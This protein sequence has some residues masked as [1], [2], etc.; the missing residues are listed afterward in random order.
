MKLVE[1]IPNFSEGRNP[2]TLDA[3]AAAIDGVEGVKLLDV[4][5]GYGANRTV[6]TFIGEPEPMGEAAFQAIRVASELIDMSVQ[7]GEHPRM[8]AT[9][10][11]PFVPVQ[12]VDMEDCVRLAE[13]VGERVASEL[14]IPIYLYEYASRSEERRL[15]ANIRSGE[16]EGLADKITNPA[17]APDFGEPLFNPKAGA[18][19]M[20]ARKFLIAY[21][22]NLN[23]RDKRLADQ[24][25]FRIREKGS[26]K[27]DTAG[28]IVRDA[29]GK[30][31]MEPG[32]FKYVRAIGW[33][34]PEYDMA[35]VSMNLTD[36]KVS[37]LHEV[38]EAACEEAEA[39]GLRVTGCEL[40]G[41]IPLEVL[42]DAGAYFLERQGSSPGLPESELIR[43][44][45]QTLGLAELGP[46]DAEKRIIEYR[47]DDTEGAFRKG[48]VNRFFDEISMGTS[49]P[50][51]GSAAAAMAAAASALVSMVANLTIGKKGYEGVRERM[52]EIA[53]GAQRLRMPLMH[54]ID[55]DARAY[56]R[57]M[58]AFRLPRGSKAEE[59]AREQAIVS[60]T[61]EAIRVPMIVLD[62]AV[63][64]LELAEEATFQ[65]N[66]NSLSD[67][68]VAAAAAR[69]A[70][71]GAYFNVLINL[72]TLD[73]YDEG[74]R[75]EAESLA[76]RANRIADGI[77]AYTREKLGGKPV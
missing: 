32:R 75:S 2:K 47:F 4:D 65:G 58:E 52:K 34:I 61:M 69:A 63:R 54:A 30:A 77:S 13:E 11:C 28:K 66:V 5:P 74:V 67:A 45:V 17:W 41:L 25:A 38:F 1:C 37:P 10:V 7:K 27:R 62:G 71:E 51:G 59:E 8:G 40:V 35:Q 64:T 21:N 76:E 68:A 24:V 3:I 6:M 56:N 60:A 55:D 49:T 72:Q 73:G 36:H 19:V 20:G 43:V 50:G 31:V 44:A 70:A 18:T 42:R 29:D 14:G 46:F 26:A 39:H 53:T 22:F 9:D 48:S 16:Y 57:V 12:G 15:L 23:T 33:Y